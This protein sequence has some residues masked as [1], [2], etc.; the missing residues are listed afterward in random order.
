MKR[1]VK[2]FRQLE[3]PLR[4][5]GWLSILL[6]ILVLGITI[7]CFY[8]KFPNGILIVD[9]PLIPT[10]HDFSGSREPWEVNFYILRDGT[11]KIIDTPISIDK[12]KNITSES[13][14]NQ[15]ADNPIRMWADKNCLFKDI[16]PVI[17]M[18]KELN[19]YKFYFI[20]IVKDTNRKESLRILIPPVESNNLWMDSSLLRIELKKDQTF[21]NGKIVDN[22]NL[23]DTLQKVS[24]VNPDIGC[25]IVPDPNI[26]HQRL[27]DVIYECIEGKISSVAVSDKP[28]LSE[29]Q[30]N[31][32]PVPAKE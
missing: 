13:I 26:T 18:F 25:L 10:S 31:P 29:V 28:V 5:V 1:L 24:S 6:I 11:I 27:I 16:S 3:S 4:F 23:H 17:N 8:Q 15:G 7:C 19:I 30:P 20:T 22:N 9:L 2:R 14:T 21:L 32:I 12:L